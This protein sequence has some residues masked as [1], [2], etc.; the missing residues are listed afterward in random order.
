VATQPG[1]Q[2]R[3]LLSV[4]AQVQKWASRQHI[5]LYILQRDQK[6][7]FDM[8]EPQG[9]YDA[10]TAYGLPDSIA[11]L[12][13]S[14]QTDVPY[15]VK[16][17]YGFTDSFIV[18]GVTKQG[19]SL[20]PLKCTLTTSMCHHWLSDLST[21]L[22]GHLLL[23]SQVASQNTLHTPLD[24]IVQPVTMVEAMDDSILFSTL[25]PTLLSLARDA[26]RFQ[27]TYGWETEWQKSC[28]YAY[29]APEFPANVL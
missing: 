12:D 10:L 26:D 22:H 17:T 28:L 2:G 23:Q 9:F 24:H 7:G 3:D 13:Q 19:G 5:P 1:V 4:I 18:N 16:T 15:S 25:L 21:H 29:Q 8:L 20:S 14:S 27:A 11:A 6:K